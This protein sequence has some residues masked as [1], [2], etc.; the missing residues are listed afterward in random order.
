M[1]IIT[2]NKKA[3]HDYE[4]FDRFEAG[5]VL[6]GDEVKSI[7]NKGIS[8]NEA[9]AT[10]HGTELF[11]LNCQIVPYSHAYLKKDTGRESRKLLLHRKELNK[12]IGSVARKGYTLLPLKVYINPRGLVKVELGLAKHRK[13]HDK[14]HMIKERD[15]ARETA[16]EIKDR[17]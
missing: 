8:I 9:F 4:I 6:K 14:R 1:K 12:L 13:A 7:R 15:I 2:T 11:L 5:I 16:R 17:R 10:I 3:F